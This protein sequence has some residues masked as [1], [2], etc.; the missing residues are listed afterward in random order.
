MSGGDE[1]M[2][3][4]HPQLL[5]EPSP[6]DREA[7]IREN[8]PDPLAGEQTWPTEEVGGLQAPCKYCQSTS[9]VQA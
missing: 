7:L 3:E 8:T 5:A 1:V 4:A 9:R 2:G 6:E